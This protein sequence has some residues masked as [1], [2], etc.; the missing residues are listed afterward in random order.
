MN[1]TIHCVCLPHL[2]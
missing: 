1:R 2:N